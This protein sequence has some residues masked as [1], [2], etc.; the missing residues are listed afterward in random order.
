MSPP[1]SLSPTPPLPNPR[2][3]HPRPYP[4]PAMPHS[5][6]AFSL[7]LSLS[8]SPLLVTG[9][10]SG[11]YAAKAPH[12]RRLYNY[13]SAGNATAVFHPHPGLVADPFLSL[14]F[15]RAFFILSHALLS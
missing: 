14:L 9:V 6:R 2:R 15:G 4:P 5:A 11:P 8:R 13:P 12:R 7:S 1:S 3:F 10:S